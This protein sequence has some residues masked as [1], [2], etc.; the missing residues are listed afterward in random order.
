MTPLPS[1]INSGHFPHRGI[2]PSVREISHQQTTSQLH[3][4]KLKQSAVSHTQDF[5]FSD[6]N[7]VCSLDLH[8]RSYLAFGSFNPA[9]SSSLNI[10]AAFEL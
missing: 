10:S 8:V 3:P 9:R 2:F 4:F 7:T 6:R 5:I 1:A